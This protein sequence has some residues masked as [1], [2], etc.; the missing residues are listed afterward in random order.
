MRPKPRP[1]QK[2]TLAL[3][4]A[5]T[6]NAS[7]VMLRPTLHSEGWGVFLWRTLVLADGFGLVSI[8]PIRPVTRNR[9]AIPFL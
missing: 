6:D 5:N 3:A 2:T 7:D 9:C 8:R 4:L 1:S